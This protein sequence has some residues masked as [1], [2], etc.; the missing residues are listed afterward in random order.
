MRTPKCLF[1]SFLVVASVASAADLTKEEKESITKQLR[2]IAYAV[3]VG[4]ADT[5][6]RLMPDAIVEASGGFDKLKEVTLVAYKLLQTKGVKIE[7]FE[8]GSDLDVYHGENHDFLIVRETIILKLQGKRV[9]IKSFVLGV[10]RKEGGDW[11]FVEGEKLTR[12]EI[13]K[14]FSDFPD[15]TLPET[16]RKILDEKT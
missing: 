13:G 6:V 8:I 5:P 15:V 11:R 9:E 3:E 2:S 7:T 4:D 12:A 14:F 16:K 10:R 1:V